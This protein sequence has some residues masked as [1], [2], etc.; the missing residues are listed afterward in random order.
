[1]A[2]K[3]KNQFKRSARRAATVIETAKIVGVTQ[4]TVQM[5][6]KDDIKN[7]K[8]LSIFMEISERHD[9]LLKEVN[10]LAPFN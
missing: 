10:Q 8:V 4:R 1:M 3:V 7:E 2:K 5:V 6:L 9:R